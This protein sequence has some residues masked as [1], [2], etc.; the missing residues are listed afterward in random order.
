MTAAALAPQHPA[1]P[2]PRLVEQ[3]ELGL[4]APICPPAPTFFGVYGQWATTPLA[5]EDMRWLRERWD[6]PFTWSSRP[7]S[8]AR[9]APPSGSP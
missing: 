4:A 9:W 5:W 1:G 6:G 2:V 3:F 8:R 7:D